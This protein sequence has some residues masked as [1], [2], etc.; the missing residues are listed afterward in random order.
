MPGETTA[1]RPEE[2]LR[3]VFAPRS[4]AVVGATDNP[5]ALGYMVY[6]NLLRDFPGRLYPVNSR[7]PAILGATA[8][9]SVADLPEPV[10]LLVVLVP[11]AQVAVVVAEAI[12]AGH[13]SA[14][15]LA[16]GFSE[17]GTEEGRDIQRRLTEMAAAAGFPIVGP[18]CNGYFNGYAQTMATFALMPDADRPTVGPVAIVSQ[19]GGFG[20]SIL[21]RAVKNRVHVGYFASTGNEADVTATDA[22]QYVIAQ[23]QVS[24]VA[25]FAEGIKDAAGFL[26]AARYAVAHDKVIVSVAPHT[27]PTVARAVM[28]HT[29]TIVGSSDVYEAVCDQYGVLRAASVDELIDFCLVLQDG[30]RMAGSRLG[31]LTQSGGAGVLMASA[32]SEAGLEIPELSPGVQRDIAAHLPAF[33]SAKNPVDTTA[34]MFP[35]APRHMAAIVNRIL[36]SDEVDALVAMTWIGNDAPANAVITAYGEQRKPVVPVVTVDPQLVAEQGLPTFA[37]PTRAIGAVAAMARVSARRPADLPEFAV[38]AARAARAARA[39]RAVRAVRARDILRR[40]GANP[41]LLESDS[42]ELLTLYGFPVAADTVCHSADEA[43]SAARQIAG[44]VVMK[45]LSYALAH[46]SDHGAVVLGVEG[47][48]EVRKAYERLSTLPGFPVDGVLVQEMV[49]GSLELA[50]GI[51]RDPVFGPVVSIGL[52]G[53]LV[54]M[55]GRPRLLVAPFDGPAAAAALD[56]LGHGRLVGAPRGMTTAQ[57]DELAAAL[58]GLGALGLELPEV[59]S[60]D[61]NPVKVSANRMVAVDGLVVLAAS[62]S[63]AP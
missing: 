50:A 54:E 53:V 44:R 52:G 11:A 28:S 2:R 5:L 32:A 57:R 51:Q 10:D 39:V 17:A 14:Y 46:K 25:Y 24:V 36:D 47:E 63:S 35:D 26:R 19:S 59:V 22:L 56:K 9:P 4:I 15:I 23:P 20:S 12:K 16:A 31:I 42:K 61:I 27:S 30:R 45:A 33:A 8:Y 38:D 41:A 6:A 43:V 49:S 18:N 13:R 3:P 58:V 21:T 60:L 62:A 7:K 48:P 55:L 29:A 40:A 37:D 34:G 1:T